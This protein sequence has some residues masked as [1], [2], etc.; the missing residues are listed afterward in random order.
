MKPYSLRWLIGFGADAAKNDLR[1]PVAVLLIQVD[2]AVQLVGARLGLHQHDR[3]VAAAELRRVGV[4]ED[5][6]FLDR[7]Q[8]RALAVLVLRR[9]VVVDA[10][11]L[12]RRAARAGAVEIDRR[13]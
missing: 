7:R 8:R 5:L 1:V 2:V 9:V 13:P 4:R 10:V 11:D 3:A 6:E 12:E